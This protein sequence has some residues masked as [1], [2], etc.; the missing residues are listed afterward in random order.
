MSKTTD[1]GNLGVAIQQILRNYG[2]SLQMAVDE[3]AEKLAKGAARDLRQES[4]KG[5]RGKYRKGW[6]VRK[7]KGGEYY[8]YNKEYRLTHLLEHGHRTRYKTGKYGKK[9][10]SKAI[11]HIEPIEREVRELFVNMINNHLKFQK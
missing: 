1:A 11:P 2:T 4:P 9:R 3:A 6:N 10:D 5:Y 7:E 8:V